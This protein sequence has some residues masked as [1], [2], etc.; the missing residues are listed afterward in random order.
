MLKE[1]LKKCDFSE[2]AV[3]LATLDH[4]KGHLQLHVFW[5]LS[6]SMPRR[7]PVSSLK[8]RISMMLN[9][10]NLKDQDKHEFQACLTIGQNILFNT[11]KRV[12][13]SV[14][15]NRHTMKREPPLPIYMGINIHTLTRS[16]KLIQQL[17]QLGISISY[18]RVMELEDLLA[19][20]VCERFFQDWSGGPCLPAERYIY[21]RCPGQHRPQPKFNHFPDLFPWYWN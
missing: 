14:A 17:Y 19:T 7:F 18:D 9:G 5:Q 10:P 1:A 16:K 12:S 20:S 3:M 2:D 8:F 13:V 11:K 15:N 4:Q 6:T 21:C